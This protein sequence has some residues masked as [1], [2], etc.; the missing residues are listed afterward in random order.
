M[1]LLQRQTVKTIIQFADGR[2]ESD[3]DRPGTIYSPTRSLDLFRKE[4]ISTGTLYVGE[5]TSGNMRE[6][7][8]RKWHNKLMVLANGC[9]AIR[10]G[11]HITIIIPD[12]VNVDEIISKTGL[13]KKEI[14]IKEI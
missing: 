12:G 1:A 6:K 11:V 13:P 8:S 4:A 9:T 14:I 10:I 7:N 2:G 3:P 5:S